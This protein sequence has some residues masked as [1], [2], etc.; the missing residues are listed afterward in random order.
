MITTAEPV[1]SGEGVGG[2]WFQW[3]GYLVVFDQRPELSVGMSP[4]GISEKNSQ[5]KRRVSAKALGWRPVFKEQCGGECG[6]ECG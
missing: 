3:A 1:G 2:G 6:S 5:V 4:V